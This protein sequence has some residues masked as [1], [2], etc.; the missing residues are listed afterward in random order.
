MH[1]S[2]AIFTAEKIAIAR[3]FTG[4]LIDSAALAAHVAHPFNMAPTDAC[5]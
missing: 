4:A 1:F 2:A 3:L 5:R